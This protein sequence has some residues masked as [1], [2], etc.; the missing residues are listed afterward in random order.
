VYVL[1]QNCRAAGWRWN[2]IIIIYIITSPGARGHSTTKRKFPKAPRRLSNLGSAE[3]YHKWDRKSSLL[4]DRGFRSP[5]SQKSPS[6][7][8]RHSRPLGGRRP[9]PRKIRLPLTIRFLRYPASSSCVARN[10]RTLFCA[11]I[12]RPDVARTAHQNDNFRRYYTCAL[13]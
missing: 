6:R 1:R 7:D 5:H 12:S 8:V 9:S 13:K 11:A 2:S 3:R 4:D 10:V